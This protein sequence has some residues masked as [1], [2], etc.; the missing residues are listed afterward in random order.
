MLITN[1]LISGLQLRVKSL[2]A[3][4]LQSNVAL[5]RVE[6]TGTLI[7]VMMMDFVKTVISTTIQVYTI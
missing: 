3:N 7:K 6:N 5:A 2:T 1:Y 4:P